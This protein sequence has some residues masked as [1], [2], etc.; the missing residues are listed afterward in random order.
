MSRAP[1]VSVAVA[2]RDGEAHLGAQLASILAQTVAVDEIVLSDDASRD[3][4]VRLAAHVL[5]GSDVD[6]VLLENDPPLGVSANFESAL[7]AAS[8]DIILLSDQDDVWAPDRVARTLAAFAAESA[9]LAVHGDARLVD[10][11]GASLGMTLL[12]A[13][14]AGPEVRARIHAGAAF[15][16]LLR[17]NLATGATMAIRRELLTRARPFPADWVHDEWLALV[18]AAVGRIDLIEAPLIDYRQHGGNQIGVE[19]ATV[20]HKIRRVLDPRG[21]RNAILARRAAVLVERLAA[22]PEAPAEVVDAA[23]GKLEF[24][25]RRAAMPARRLARVPAVIKGL[26]RGDYRRFASRGDADILRD[27]LQPS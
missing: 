16:V 25:S 4:T 1:R 14:E 7:A 12:D 20:R 22:L 10:G 5:A 9:L 26:R 24:E 11:G 13:L 18:A 3:G 15:P 27:L 2:T 8:G 6:V 17:R 19:A 23:R 21:T